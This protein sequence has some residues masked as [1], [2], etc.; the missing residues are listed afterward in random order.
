MTMELGQEFTLAY[1]F[2]WELPISTATQESIAAY[3]TDE[4]RIHLA[5]HFSVTPD[6]LEL[7]AQVPSPEV[8]VAVTNNAATPWEALARMTHDHTRDVKVAANE[9]IEHLPET[10]RNAARAMVASPMRRLRSRFSA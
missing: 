8:R 4:D 10:Q 6:T 9:A 7:L 5:S 1:S 2:H 3:G